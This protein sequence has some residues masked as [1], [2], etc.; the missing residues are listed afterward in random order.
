M[1]IS[2]PPGGC[3]VCRFLTCRCKICAIGHRSRIR[4]FIL[5]SRISDLFHRRYT[6]RCRPFTFLVRQEILFGQ[7]E[8]WHGVRVRTH[9]PRA[10][11]RYR[12][13][14]IRG[15]SRDERSMQKRVAPQQGPGSLPRLTL[16][17]TRSPPAPFHR[18]QRAGYYYFI[19]VVGTCNLPVSV[20]PG[21]ELGSDG[22]QGDHGAWTAS[23]RHLIRS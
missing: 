9:W 19:D 1:R 6:Y 13:E 5:W 16:R 10:K 14:N 2:E 20:L 22:S 17:F 23:P 21:W 11:K 15:R 18:C 3:S 7:V 8:V 12:Q 4:L